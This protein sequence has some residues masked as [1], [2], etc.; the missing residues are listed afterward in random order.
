MNTTSSSA[1][2]IIDRLNETAEAIERTAR[3]AGRAGRGAY[4]RAAADTEAV[5]AREWAALRRDLADLASNADLAA[6]PEVRRLIDQMKHSV[7]AASASV[8]DAAEDVRRRTVEKAESVDAMVHD[9][10][11]KT[12]GL[13]ALAGIAVGLMIGR[14]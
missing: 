6:M 8:G 1:E 4:D 11:W 14:R 7:A 5:F 12:A 10:P 2:A 3:R 9:A 13:A